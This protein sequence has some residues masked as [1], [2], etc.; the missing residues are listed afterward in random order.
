M[1]NA[2]DNKQKWQVSHYLVTR[3]YQGKT[4]AERSD[5]NDGIGA[6]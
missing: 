2:A 4:E 6:K 3:T 5:A 1:L